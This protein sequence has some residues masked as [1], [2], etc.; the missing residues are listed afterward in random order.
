MKQFTVIQTTCTSVD[1]MAIWSFA[2]CFAN[3][4]TD[5]NSK[6]ATI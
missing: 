5:R 6:H 1:P 4:M 2:P 3:H